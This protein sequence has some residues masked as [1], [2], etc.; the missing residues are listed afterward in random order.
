MKRFVPAVLVVSLLLF[1]AAC[2]SGSSESSSSASPADFQKKLQEDLIKA[3]P[4]AVIEIPEG[5]FKLDKTLSLKVDKV[6]IRGK[7]MDKTILSFAGQKA[8]SAGMLVKANDFTIEDLAIEDAAG[9]ALKVEDGTNITIR[10]VRVEW[11]AGPK[12]TN[13]PYGIY[14]VTCKNVLIEDSVAIAASDAGIYVGQSDTVIMRRNR[15]ER[16]VAGIEIENTKNADVYENTATNNTGGIMA[17]NL[18]DLPVQG[19]ENVRI[20]NNKI[21]GNNTA[22]FAPT[23]QIVAGLPTGTGVLVMAIR[24]VEIFK[25]VIKDNNT[26]NIN[27]TTFSPPEDKPIKN[28]KYNQF[29]ASVYIHDNE[30]SGGGASPDVRLPKIAGLTRAAGKTFADVLYDGVI[31]P[32][33]GK[34]GTMADAKICLDNNGAAT[35]LN[36][37]AANGFKKMGKDAKAYKCALPALAA[38]SLPQTGAAG[39]GM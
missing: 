10:R 29:V 16:N 4:G 35:F 24:N 33:D 37:D 2:N 7:G 22:N 11:T 32:K 3:A 34:P 15:A 26:A 25:N 9:D 38:I 6:T 13:G 30:I 12:E 8:G 20:Y 18:P 5:K 17:F 36:Y 1:A 23:S 21:I 27:I 31:E 39:G 28:E 19:G 14:P